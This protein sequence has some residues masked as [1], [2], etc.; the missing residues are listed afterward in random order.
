M[1]DNS[2]DP[3]HLLNGSIQDMSFTI[4]EYSV[5]G[6]KTNESGS[7]KEH[8]AELFEKY[9]M[10]TLLT[11]DALFNNRPRVQVLQD[12]GKD[13]LFCIKNNQPDRMDAVTQTFK[14]IEIRPPD[15]AETAKKRAA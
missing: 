4:D 2:G 14:D 9:P 5:K 1:K 13:Y 7:L 8:A 11:G 10:R 6:E 15:A 3:I 12:L